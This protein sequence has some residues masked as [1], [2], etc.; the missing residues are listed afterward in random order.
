MKK[1]LNIII[2][3]AFYFICSI[4][5]TGYGHVETHPYLNEIM[6]LKF[7]DKITTKDFVNIDKF[8]NYEFNWNNSDQPNLT[9]M[10][11]GGD[12]LTYTTLPADEERTY[13]PMKWISE[14]GWMED[15][16]WGPS[17]LCHFYDPMAIDDG[18][19]YLTDCSSLLESFPVLKQI[20]EYASIDALTWATTDSRHP[21]TWNIAKGYIVEALKEPNLELRKGIMAKAYRCLGQVLHLVADMGCTPH[22]RNDSHPPKIAYVIGDPD[23]YE[24]ICKKLDVYSLWQID[25]PNAYFKS[26]FDKAEKF[27]VIFDKLATYTNGGF[28]SGQTIYTDRYKPV[29]RPDNPYPN[30]MMTE[31]NY[32][33][34]E[35]AYHRNYDGVDVVMC[36]DKVPVPYLARLVT[37]K[38][39]TRGRPYLDY[40]CVKSMA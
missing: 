34:E 16:P 37:G 26:Q 25:P 10:A 24:E 20:K 14:G 8:K 27:D 33:N 7:L 4:L 11:C 17:S 40:D 29:V 15:E 6:V 21:W 19:K 23:P 1:I 9:G 30:P 28:F 5:F 18:K 3:I 39:S 12:G 2:G 35:Y 22:V 31:A 32:N 36:K 13:T 38:D